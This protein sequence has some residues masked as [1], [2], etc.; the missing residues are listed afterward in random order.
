MLQGLGESDPGRIQLK[1]RT[2]KQETKNK[3]QQKMNRGKM[4][5]IVGTLMISGIFCRDVLE[6]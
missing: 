1:S 3:S 6:K 5:N 4:V 2:T